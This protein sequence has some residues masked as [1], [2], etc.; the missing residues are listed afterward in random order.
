M[1]IVNDDMIANMESNKKW[2]R[3]VT[4]LFLRGRQL[5][6][7]HPFISQSHFKVTKS[8]GLN[9]RHYTIMEIPKK[10][11]LQQMAL[12]HSSDIKFKDFIKL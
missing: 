8:I 12:N 4:K 11:E 9:A 10:R 6:I 5:N 2:S 3:I 1:L 7:S